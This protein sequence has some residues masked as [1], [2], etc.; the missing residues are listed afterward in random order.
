LDLVTKI[1]QVEGGVK[2]ILRHNVSNS[3]ILRY[4]YDLN[5]WIPD[6]SRNND[7]NYDQHVIGLYAGYVLKLKK[8]SIKT[9][10][11]AEGTLNQGYFKS[12]KDTTFTNRMINLI[13]YITLSKDLEKGQNIKVSYTQKLSRPGIWYLNPY[14]DD[15]DPLNISYGN[16]D[17]DA[18]VSNTFELG[19]MKFSNKFNINVSINGAFTNNAIQS[20]STL[21]STGVKTTTYK[22]IGK[23]QQFGSYVY[24]SYRPGNKLTFNINLGINYSILESNDSR[25]LKNEGFNYNGSM[26]MRYNAWKN[27]IVSFY[28]GYYSPSIRL[29]GQYGKY[30]YSNINVTQELFKKKLSASVSVSNPFRSYFKFEDSFDDPTFRQNMVSC[31][32][33]RM[34]RFNLSYSFGQMNG[35]I[36]KARRGIKNE[37]VKEGGNSSSGS[38]GKGG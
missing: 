8:I 22:N 15:T 12:A 6:E 11:R 5:N 36:K 29:Q 2:Y 33:N 3:E 35:E 16:P 23:V 28:T 20:I 17:L 13:P 9:G 18:E 10:L 21:S 7:L 1:H 27:G 26:N 38:E 34:L 32:Y 30:W 37:D 4:N 14:V 19:Y 31:Y 24:G 25:N